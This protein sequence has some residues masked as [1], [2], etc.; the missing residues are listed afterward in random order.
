MRCMAILFVLSTCDVAVADPVN[1]AGELTE[2]QNTQ[3]KFCEA[4]LPCKWVFSLFDTCTQSRTWL[5]NL[6]VINQPSDLSITVVE[7]SVRQMAVVE[8]TAEPDAPS[9]FNCLP[10]FYDRS[11]CR[12]LLGIESIPVRVAPL[13]RSRTPDVDRRARMLALYQEEEQSRLRLGGP[14]GSA[15]LALSACAEARGRSD[16]SATCQRAQNQVA[17]CNAAREDWLRRKVALLAEIDQATPGMGT[18]Y[19]PGVSPLRG[20][21]PQADGD[22]MWNDTVK[23]MRSMEI[24]ACPATLPNTL[25]TPE[26][27]LA[28]WAAEEGKSGD[29]VA[30]C[31]GMS[32][33]TFD[34]ID[35]GDIARSV[36]LTDRFEAACAREQQT[37][38]DRVRLARDRIATLRIAQEAAAA[39]RRSTGFG[40]S[41][42]KDAISQAE[43]E[44]RD[45]SVRAARQQAERAARQQ[46]ISTSGGGTDNS[47]EVVTGLLSA[48]TGVANARA[49]QSGARANAAAQQL[50]QMQAQVR[51][52]QQAQQAQQA[53]AYKAQARQ[54]EAFNQRA[55]EESRYYAPVTGCVTMS[56]NA[57]SLFKSCALNRCGRPLEVI[58]TG[59]QWSVGAGLC[60]PTGANATITAVCEKNDTYDRTRQRCRR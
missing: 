39:P 12:Q 7:S 2:V 11:L 47:G 40:A 45:P 42:F 46:E 44:Q 43:A 22:Q 23:S 55:A 5:T 36:L 51:A 37:Y 9:I 13:Q 28:A 3:R 6:G 26:Q 56:S 48:L 52:Q 18:N 1:C 30:R 17:A 16:R 54:A 4:F 58:Y 8:M 41:L 20:L 10:G 53:D 35:E 57:N 60:W 15:V 38:A 19:T 24:A 33:D 31:D 49:A 29:I 32:R 25:L 50:A 14:P 59:G 34:T 21:G 27:A